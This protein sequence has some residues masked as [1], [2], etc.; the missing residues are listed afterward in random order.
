MGL[1]SLS[2]VTIGIAITRTADIAATAKANGQPDPTYLWLWSTIQATLGEFS[3]MPVSTQ[4]STFAYPILQCTGAAVPFI[5]LAEQ[6]CTQ[7]SSLRAS[8]L[9]PNS[10]LNLHKS[11]FGLQRIHIIN[12]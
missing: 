3:N 4:T 9:S 7:L 10:S 2:I 8:Q 6:T 5:T 1:F 12:G 11:L